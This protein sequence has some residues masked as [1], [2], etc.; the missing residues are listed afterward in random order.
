MTGTEMGAAGASGGNMQGAV[1]L[2]GQHAHA[3]SMRGPCGSVQA[4]ENIVFRRRYVQSEAANANY[5][6]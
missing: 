2:V 6:V 1:Q 3:G 4:Q 5:Y